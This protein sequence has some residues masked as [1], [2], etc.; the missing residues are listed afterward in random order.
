LERRAETIANDDPVLASVRQNAELGN[1][2]GSHV[3]KIEDDLTERR[4]VAGCGSSLPL[5]FAFAGQ[6]VW[7]PHAPAAASESAFT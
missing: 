5:S 2:E 6:L 1:L 3:E 7:Q 4:N